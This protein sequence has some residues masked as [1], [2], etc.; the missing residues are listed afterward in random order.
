MKKDIFIKTDRWFKKPSERKCP[1]S[2][3]SKIELYFYTSLQY[4]S[5]QH[6]YYISIRLVK[7]LYPSIVGLC[8]VRAWVRIPFIAIFAGI[9][10][11]DKTLWRSVFCF[12]KIKNLN[13]KTSMQP[14]FAQAGSSDEDFIQI[15]TYDN[16]TWIRFPPNK[17]AKKKHNV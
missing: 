11:A 13:T 16:F 5:D 17:P 10:R 12:H 8:L 9:P 2:I 6:Y 1:V 15:N 4:S 3:W 7:T 14:I